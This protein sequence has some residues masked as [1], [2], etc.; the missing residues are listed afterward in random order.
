[1]WCRS[2]SSSFEAS[3]GY[4]MEIRPA[5]LDAR[6]FPISSSGEYHRMPEPTESSVRFSCYELPLHGICPPGA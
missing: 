1:M 2:T 5:F 3:Y 4:V 6:L